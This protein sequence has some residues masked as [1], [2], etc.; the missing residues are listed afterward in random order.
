V[1]AAKSSQGP[2][3][4]SSSKRG[5]NLKIPVVALASD[6]STPSDPDPATGGLKKP[7]LSAPRNGWL[8]RTPFE[9]WLSNSQS[10]RSNI[11]E[12]SVSD[13]SRI[14]VILGIAVTALAFFLYLLTTAHYQIGGDTPD[15][16]LA[17]KTW[18]VAHPPGYPTLVLLGHIFSFL[19][20]GST[21]FRINLLATV[22]SSATVAFV[23][24]T[25][26]RLTRRAWASALGASAL[27]F[28]PLFWK[29]SLQI[30]TFPLNNLL[31][32]AVIYF[33]IRWHQDNERSVFLYLAAGLFGLGL[34]NQ[35]T[36]LLLAPA[37]AYV[38]WLN[39]RRLVV[40]PLLIGWS[41]LW[42]VVGL[43][44][45]LYVPL[46]ATFGHSPV[47]W[48][49]ASSLGSLTNLILRKD[50]GGT[51]VS[52]GSSGHSGQFLLAVGYLFKEVGWVLG[53]SALAG[54]VTAYSRL[55]WYFVFVLAA[56]VASILEFAVVGG[57]DPHVSTALFVLERFYLMVL[58]IMSPLAAVGVVG[59]VEW[60]Q[61]RPMLSDFSP[62]KVVVQLVVA[63]AIVASSAGI[64]ASNY[65][66]INVSNDRVAENYVRDVLSGLPQN[67][68]LFVTGDFADF[69]ILYAQ[70]VEHLRRDVTVLVSPLLAASWYS[71]QLRSEHQLTLP[72]TLTTLSIVTSNPG[73]QFYFVG[74]PPDKTLAGHY[75]F[76][77]QGLA[78]QI[79]PQAQSLD[80]AKFASQ[81]EALLASYHVP[82]AS[83]IKRDSFESFILDTY[84]NIPATL[85]S[86]FSARNS[87]GLAIKYFEQAHRMDPRNEVIIKRLRQIKSGVGA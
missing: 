53:V 66:T 33:I 50:Y 46:A 42:I 83:T 54:I 27:A 84:A 62:A 18:G 13:A 37:I 24:L 48:D 26:L 35:Q 21:A 30:E 63:I 73:R 36:V 34:T 60:L 85:G 9:K 86:N 1:S 49:H 71:A 51:T 56:L 4:G 79:I 22:T 57:L 47:N 28:T 25:G 31:V 72:S 69:P 74:E 8:R 3:K 61:N 29:W 64:V 45:Y 76:A 77:I 78:S 44:P 17:V 7:V 16:L 80:L 10:R 65:S 59:F 11:D 14:E 52:L 81:N 55:R 82:R 2:S 68:V 67:A 15:F 75:Y 20:F 39:R 38:L 12:S 70:S 40:E 19:P 23:Y 41:V 43:V 5:P 32:A 58:V 87:I 6:E